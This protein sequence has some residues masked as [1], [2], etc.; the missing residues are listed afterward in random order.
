VA[1]NVR[2]PHVGLFVRATKAA[3]LRVLNVPWLAF[4]NPSVTNMAN[5]IIVSEDFR[6]LFPSP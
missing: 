1:I 4:S 3:S 2:W 5:A 6:S